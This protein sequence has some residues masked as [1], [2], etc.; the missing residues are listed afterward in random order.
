M[1]KRLRPYW[2]VWNWNAS[3]MVEINTGL[4]WWICLKRLSTAATGKLSA[5]PAREA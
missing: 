3:N 4:R 1:L 2:R 5:L